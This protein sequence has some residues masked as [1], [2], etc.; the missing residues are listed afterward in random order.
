MKVMDAEEIWENYSEISRK[1]INGIIISLFSCRACHDLCLS[2][3]PR[4]RAKGKA[5]VCRCCRHEN[6]DHISPPRHL[7]VL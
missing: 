7:C 2:I 1:R 6:L 4:A 5:I 3:T